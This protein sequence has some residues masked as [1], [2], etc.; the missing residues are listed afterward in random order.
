[1]LQGRHIRVP[2]A[3]PNQR[4]PAT[5]TAG[6]GFDHDVSEKRYVCR[7]LNKLTLRLTA[8]GGSLRA[9]RRRR[10]VITLLQE[11]VKRNIIGLAAQVRVVPA[12][13]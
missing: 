11:I 12:P 10:I 7:I 8:V 3:L 1:M 6:F 2:R 4:L 13:A 9:G 5:K